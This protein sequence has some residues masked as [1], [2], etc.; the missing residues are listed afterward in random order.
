MKRKFLRLAS[1]LLVSTVFGG[2]TA[3]SKSE[4]KSNEIIKLSEAPQSN[5]VSDKPVTFSMLYSGEFNSNYKSLEKMKEMTNVTLDIQAVPDSDYSTKSKLLMNTD[6][7]PDFISKTGADLELALNGKLLPISD[8]FDQMP[9][10]M[11]FIKKNNLQSLIDNATLSDGKVYQLPINT[12]EQRISSK[13]IFMRTDIF[14]KNGL[15]I[16]KTYDEL[17]ESCKKLKQIYPDIYPIQ[18]IYGL[19]NLLD[20]MSPSFGTSGGWG[21]GRNGFHYDE[22]KDE[23]I[24]ASTS[25]EYKTMLQYLNKLYS[26]GLIDREFTSMDSNLYSQKI[27]NGEAFVLMAEWLGCEITGNEVGKTSNPDFN[28]QPVYPLEGPSGKA[29]VGRLS[30]STQTAIIPASVKNKEYFSEFIRWIDWM[31]SDEG[32]NLFTWGI[33][34]ETYKVVD[35]KK[36]FLDNIIT[37]NNPNGTLDLQKEYGTANNCLTFVY[38]YDEEQARMLPQYK[39]LHEKEIEN[40]CIP[41]PVPSLRL[42]LDDVEEEKLVALGLNDYRGQMIE[43]FIMGSESFDN[44]DSFVKECNNKGAIKLKEMYNSVWE[45]QNQNN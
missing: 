37:P 41:L 24:Y 22:N 19:G 7:M 43:K 9:N 13:Q 1:I 44:W 23:W 39:E 45:K 12:K 17:Y 27:S 3:C 18:V 30:N 26:E 4:V 20:M 28:L 8:Y 15:S 16:P 32:T 34:N 38:P 21:E 33:E 25:N 10:F 2:F 31:Y 36:E 5:P 35:G 14:E 6:Q 42:N 29:L 40:N 11:N